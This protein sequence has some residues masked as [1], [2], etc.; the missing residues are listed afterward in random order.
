MLLKNNQRKPKQ[1][2]LSYS[3]TGKLNVVKISVLPKLIYGLNP[4]PR[5]SQHMCVN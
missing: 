4:I 1:R 5:K 3:W 2:Y